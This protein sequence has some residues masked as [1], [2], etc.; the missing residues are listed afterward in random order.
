VAGSNQPARLL[1]EDLSRYLDR[2]HRDLAAIVMLLA[3]ETGRSAEEL[4]ADALEA[5]PMVQ[6]FRL[7][8]HLGESGRCAAEK[9]LDRRRCPF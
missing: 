1:P 7:G 3:D 4:V 2:E 6:A 5:S 9:E 8:A